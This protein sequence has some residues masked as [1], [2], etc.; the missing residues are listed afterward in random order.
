MESFKLLLSSDAQVQG[1]CPPLPEALVHS[2]KQVVAH[3]LQYLRDHADEELKSKCAKSFF[4]NSIIH[5]CL[6]IPAGWSEEAK[7]CMRQ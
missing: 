1:H 5:Y 4:D 3:F 2:K 6:T 7:H